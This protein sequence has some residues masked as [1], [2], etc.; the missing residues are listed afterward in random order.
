MIIRKL[1]YLNLETEL[2]RMNKEYKYIPKIK[3]NGMQECYF[4]LK[5]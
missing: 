3:F 5:N 4:N 1:N 2:K